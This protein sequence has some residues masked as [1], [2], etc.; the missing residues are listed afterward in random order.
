MPETQQSAKC[1]SVKCNK[2]QN[3]NYKTEATEAQLKLNSNV[4]Q[5]W[6][7]QK[8]TQRKN[9]RSVQYTYK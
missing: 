5:K 1:N 9:K 6:L 2:T 3:V 8:K 7:C 4:I